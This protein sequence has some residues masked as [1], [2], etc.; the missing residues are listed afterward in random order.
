MSATTGAGAGLRLPSMK[1]KPARSS[2]FVE[3]AAC[4]LTPITGGKP[5][6]A[7][8]GFSTYST[9]PSKRS[10]SASLR[11][12]RKPPPSGTEKSVCDAKRCAPAP[13]S[14]SR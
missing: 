12:K 2:T 11:L 8:V 13:A 7:A 4:E 5:K 1:L 6:V 10:A 14:S 9:I 3:R